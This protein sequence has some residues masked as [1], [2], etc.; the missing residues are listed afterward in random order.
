LS[1]DSKSAD[2]TSNSRKLGNMLRGSS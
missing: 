1:S 2:S